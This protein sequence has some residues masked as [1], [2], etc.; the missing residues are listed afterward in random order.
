MR[1]DSTLIY[2]LLI[3]ARCCFGTNSSQRDVSTQTAEALA[4]KAVAPTRLETMGF[5]ALSKMLDPAHVLS[6]ILPELEKADS[7]AS[8]SVPKAEFN[9]VMRASI[10]ALTAA[11]CE[12]VLTQNAQFHLFFIHFFKTQISSRFLRC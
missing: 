2:D 1:L 4:P 11:D 3:S 12:K 7:N 6:A 8:G 9:R 5:V 10:A